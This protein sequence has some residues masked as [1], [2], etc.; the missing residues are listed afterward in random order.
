M[1]EQPAGVEQ[2]TDEDSAV[3]RQARFG[4]LPPRVRPEDLVEMTDLEPRP[5]TPEPGPDPK[6]LWFAG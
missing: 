6:G 5:V 4:E 1:T 3:L 2:F